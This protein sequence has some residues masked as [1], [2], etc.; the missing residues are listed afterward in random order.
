MLR[1]IKALEEVA[2]INDIRLKVNQGMTHEAL[3]QLRRDTYLMSPTVRRP[4][5]KNE[6]LQAARRVQVLPDSEDPI[7]TN[8]LSGDAKESREH[9]GSGER[10]EEDQAASTRVMNPQLLDLVVRT[11]RADSGQ[12]SASTESPLAPTHLQAA[13]FK[14]L[15]VHDLASKLSDQA[16]YLRDLKS[17]YTTSPGATPVE[18]KR[19]KPRTIW[20]SPNPTTAKA[21]ASVPVD[22]PASTTS[23]GQDK[24]TVAP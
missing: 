4:L 9:P 6:C 15:K 22:P 20:R 17:Y 11:A 14:L 18:V 24:Q 10:Q 23:V 7:S 16:T 3:E 13:E 19:A 2:K 1:Q 5:L 12:D 21:L 8:Q